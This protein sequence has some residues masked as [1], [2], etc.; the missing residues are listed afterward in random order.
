MKTSASVFL[1]ML[2]LFGGMALAHEPEPT[3]FFPFAFINTSAGPTRPDEQ[4]RLASL[5]AQLQAAL[6][7]SG[8]CVA[9][10]LSAVADQARQFE[11]ASCN[12]CEVALARKAGAAI[13]ITGWVQKVSELILNINVVVRRVDTGAPIAAGSVDIRGNTDE[14]WSRG[15]AWLVR[16]RLHPSDW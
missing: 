13:S 12:G 5:N 15:L 11:M 6:V 9:V 1:A 4:V 14:S 16:N 10:D 8:C 7:H 3:A 2:W